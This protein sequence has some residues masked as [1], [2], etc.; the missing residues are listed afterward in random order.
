MTCLKNFRAV[1]EVFN[2]CERVLIFCDFVFLTQVLLDL[3]LFVKIR[4]FKLCVR[5]EFG[6]VTC[7][8]STRWV[9]ILVLVSLWTLTIKRILILMGRGFF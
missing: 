3:R 7:F 8:L 5:L 9:E 1:I 4:Y 6:S 2:F